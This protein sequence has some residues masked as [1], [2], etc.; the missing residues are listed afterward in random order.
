M[1]QRKG[2][3]SVYFEPLHI[4]YIPLRKEVVDIV[5]TNV[6]ET[7]GDLTK[8]G[9]GNT[10]VTLHFKKRPHLPQQPVYGLWLSFSMIG[11][12]LTRFRPDEYY[13]DG[14]GVMMEM[15]R[16]GL[17]GLK[18]TRN[19]LKAPSNTL[20]GLKAGLARGVK[21]KAEQ[22]IKKEISK[23]AKKALSNKNVKQAV[24][25]ASALFPKQTKKARD[26]FGV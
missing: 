25:V 23:R 7:N 5:E 15:V 20:Q 4:Q 10:I 11:G 14:K 8:F 2:R 13:Q 16:G 6:A 18:R 21:R 12:S 3:G 17:R 26:I 19:P 9:L 22:V 1:Y 24:R